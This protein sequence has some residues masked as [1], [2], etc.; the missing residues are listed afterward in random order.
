MMGLQS[1][2]MKGEQRG[3]NGTGVF[4]RINNEEKP[5]RHSL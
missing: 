5:L 3:H 1:N 2:G 4:L